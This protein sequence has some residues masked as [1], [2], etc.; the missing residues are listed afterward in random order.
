MESSRSEWDVRGINWYITDDI[1]WDW[2]P[3]SFSNHFEP[4]NSGSTN[5]IDAV[6]PC[7]YIQQ[8]HPPG[9]QRNHHRMRPFRLVKIE[10]SPMGNPRW[11]NHMQNPRNPATKNVERWPNIFHTYPMI[12]PALMVYS[13]F[14]IFLLKLLPFKPQ[15]RPC[16][17]FSPC[18]CHRR[19]NENMGFTLGL[20]L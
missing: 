2:H 3:T 5:H 20:W 14:Y 13:F 10:D 11:L 7:V 16:S 8:Y 19:M 12:S 17:S 4:P 6:N 1:I 15:V 18:N 9:Y